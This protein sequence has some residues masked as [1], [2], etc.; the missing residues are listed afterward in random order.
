MPSGEKAR[1]L[2]EPWPMCHLAIGLLCIKHSYKDPQIFFGLVQS[3][4]TLQDHKTAFMQ[5][6]SHVAAK[7]NSNSYTGP[8]AI[9]QGDDSPFSS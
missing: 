8:I 1:P 7:T 5:D 4:F 9:K 6:A 3:S 2:I